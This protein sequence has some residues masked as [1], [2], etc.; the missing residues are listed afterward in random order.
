MGLDGPLYAALVIA[1]AGLVGSTAIAE[2]V[3]EGHPSVSLGE[4]VAL[5]RSKSL[6]GVSLLGFLA[7]F[8][9]MAT[10]FGFTPIFAQQA[11]ASKEQLGYLMSFFNLFMTLS[12]FL[13]GSVLLRFFSER[14]ILTAGF[15]V[16]A[17]AVLLTPLASRVETLYLVQAVNGIGIGLILP[18]LM[19]LAIRPFPTNKKATAMGF[20]QSTYALGM[21]LGPILSGWVG[22]HLGLPSIFI[23]NGLLCLLPPLVPALLGNLDL[24]PEVVSQSSVSEKD[25]P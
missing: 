16:T 9:M 3:P 17:G 18:L 7:T 19:G 21:T 8:N 4:L 10:T 13:A 20:Y 1:F 24:K 14:K 5:G 23:L 11:G 2:R 22:A 25:P 6:L 15:M 12:L